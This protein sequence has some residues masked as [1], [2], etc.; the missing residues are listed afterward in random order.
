VRRGFFIAGVVVAGLSLQACASKPF[1]YGPVGPKAPFGYTDRQ[2][3]DGGFTVLMK[4][5][6]NGSPAELRANFD[7]RAGELCPAGVARTNVFR[8]THDGYNAPAPAVYGSVG[9]GQRVWTGAELEGYVY[10]KPGATAPA[11][12]A[13]PAGTP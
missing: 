4:M 3:A 11:P 8:V 10:C 6:A 12:Q 7:R 13:A 9:I 5:P 1:V 2:N